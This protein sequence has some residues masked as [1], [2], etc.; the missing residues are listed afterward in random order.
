MNNKYKIIKMKFNKKNIYHYLIFANYSFLFLLAYIIS[1]FKNKKN[2]TIFLM[3][4][5][6]QG[7]LESF[8]YLNKLDYKIKYLTFNKKL[9]L[10]NSYFYSYLKF[11]NILEML[12]SKLIIASHGIL[13][14]G[15]VKK[16]GVKTINIGHGV[17]TSI[18]NLS[19]SELSKFDEVWLSS[20][21]DKNI[22]NNACH[23]SEPNLS[24]TGFL[25]HYFLLQNEKNKNNL[26][27]TTSLDKYIL[28]APTASS[29][30]KKDKLSLF[31]LHNLEFLNKLNLFAKNYNYKII[32]KP[33]IKDYETNK[34]DERTYEFIK[35]ANNL[36]YFN[37]FNYPENY[38]PIITELLITDWSSIYLDFLVLNKN[39]IFVDAPKRRKNIY[40]SEY[41][42][43][44][45]INRCMSYNELDLEL[46]SNIQNLRNENM[47]KLKEL[48]FQN[49][50]INKVNELSQKRLK[51]LI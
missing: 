49:L 2:Q 30:E 32:I 20:E 39:I 21:F 31:H 27:P 14:H 9:A 25:S 4:H 16:R 19:K 51:N 46:M 28:Y 8:Y 23:Y 33:H 45:F 50:K 43:N 13:F 40:L 35:N 12:N 34:F 42:N 29:G 22:L 1:K 6:F 7:N 47:S 15:L 17:Q 37:D 44:E 3:G 18:V 38:L 11:Q 41:F 26:L 36:I 48:I 10:S 24:V 5:S